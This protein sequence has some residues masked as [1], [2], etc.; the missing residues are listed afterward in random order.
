MVVL[1]AVWANGITKCGVEP[2]GVAASM[3]KWG[4]RCEVGHLGVAANIATWVTKCEVDLFGCCWLY[5]HMGKN[6]RWSTMVLL[7]IW[8]YEKQYVRWTFLVLLA[9]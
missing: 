5:D 9:V 2:F 8:P 1:L 6:V 7:P 4:T 3:A